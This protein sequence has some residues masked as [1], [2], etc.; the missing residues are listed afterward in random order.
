MPVVSVISLKGGVGKTSVVL[1]L[2]GAALER[3]LSTLVVDLDPQANASTGLGVD[4]GSLATPEVLA[5]PRMAVFDEALL[6]SAWTS[7][8]GSVGRVDV[9]AG[10]P[11]LEQLDDPKPTAASLRRL[12]TALRRLEQPYDIVLLDC[13]PTLRRLTRTG[14]DASDRV[15]V[16]AEPGLFSVQGADRA[17]RAV[18]EERAHNEAL[19]PLGVVVNRYRERNP[20]HR[21]RLDELRALFGPLVLTPPLPERSVIQQAQG[22]SMPVQQWGTTASREVSDLFD[23]LLTRALRSRSRRAQ[24]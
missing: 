17:L 14:L 22:A 13:P 10:S 3:G 7:P 21:Y 12:S 19:Q 1:G 24:G 16:V 15:L 18:Q 2:A 8:N 11:R 6:P 4:A 20:E 9:L 5:D 23:R